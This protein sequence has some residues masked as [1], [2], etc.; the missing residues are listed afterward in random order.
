MF[1]LY[2]IRIDYTPNSYTGETHENKQRELVATFDDNEKAEKF[3]KSCKLK[4]PIEHIWTNNEIFKR[5]SLLSGYGDYEIVEII[6]PVPHN[7][8]N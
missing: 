4:K 8:K 6:K 5:K 1:E 7:P 2:G 3:V